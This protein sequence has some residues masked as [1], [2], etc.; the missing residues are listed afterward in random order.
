M[1]NFLTVLTLCVLTLTTSSVF[2]EKYDETKRTERLGL[3]YYDGR[4]LYVVMFGFTGTDAAPVG[5]SMSYYR[6]FT[7][8]NLSDYGASS[9]QGEGR[10]AVVTYGDVTVQ[11]R[12]FY[13]VI[14]ADGMTVFS[15]NLAYSY[16]YRAW[17]LKLLEEYPPP[18]YTSGDIGVNIFDAMLEPL[19]E[20]LR[21]WLGVVFAIGAVMFGWNFIRELCTL[22][23][24]GKSKGKNG[25]ASGPLSYSKLSRR[26]RSFYEGAALGSIGIESSQFLVPKAIKKDVDFVT[27]A[28][29]GLEFDEKTRESNRILMEMFNR[30]STKEQ[31]AV[32]KAFRE[33]AFDKSFEDSAEKRFLA[34]QGEVFDDVDNP[35]TGRSKRRAFDPLTAEQFA[36]G[37]WGVGEDFGL[38]TPAAP[39]F[40]DSND[41]P[42]DPNDAL[43]EAYYD[44]NGG[45]PF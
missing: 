7:G 44:D 19:S 22:D 16:P 36:Q 6:V 26:D 37:Y 28:A 29:F 10:K 9:F 4:P 30:L 5:Y 18:Q 20:M 2:A 42:F 40:I 8:D 27:G 13:S 39:S 35:F 21:G 12:Y 25:K 33:S 23:F 41:E 34:Y 43:D 14:D 38:E 24:S 32:L 1:R 31:K 11:E 3:S 17:T 15:S 45:T